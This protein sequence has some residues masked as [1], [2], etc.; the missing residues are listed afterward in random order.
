LCVC[1]SNKK[2]V[3]LIPQAELFPLVSLSPPT[4]EI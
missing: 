3:S 1:V 2:N 4:S